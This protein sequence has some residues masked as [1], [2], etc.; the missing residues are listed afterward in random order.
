MPRRH[1]LLLLPFIS[2]RT[3]VASKEENRAEHWTPPFSPHKG[4]RTERRLCLHITPP[5]HSHLL[6]LRFY[7]R[8]SWQIASSSGFRKD[9]D[10]AQCVF[11][12]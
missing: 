9:E 4:E 6:I 5:P 10:R 8:S 1:L 11:D 3:P 2:L 12:A 7:L